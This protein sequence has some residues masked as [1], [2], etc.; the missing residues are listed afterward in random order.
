[1]ETTP[2]LINWHIVLQLF[3]FVILG[4]AVHF[5]NKL[6]SA[7]KCADFT[8]KRFWKENLLGYISA[9]IFCMVGLAFIGNSI[10]LVAGTSKMVIAFS[11]GVGGGSLI[12]SFISKIQK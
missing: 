7:K 9:I 12:R 6:D 4:L 1:M 2:S 3:P 10:E 5:L 11:M 8:I